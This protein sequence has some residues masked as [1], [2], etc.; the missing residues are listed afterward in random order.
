LIFLFII[1]FSFFYITKFFGA[2]FFNLF[3]IL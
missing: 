3:L 2:T 1:W